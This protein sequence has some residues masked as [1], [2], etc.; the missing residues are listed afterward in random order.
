MNDIVDKLTKRPNFILKHQNCF[1][2]RIKGVVIPQHRA[3]DIDNK[4]DFSIASS[5]IK[6]N[7]N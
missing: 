6:K 2:G 1:E 7:R 4:F 3:I 5:L